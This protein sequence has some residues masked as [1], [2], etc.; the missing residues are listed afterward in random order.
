MSKT[1]SC[2]PMSLYAFSY[3]PQGVD[4]QPRIGLI[5][6]RD[7]WRQ[8]GHMQDL[9]AFFLTARKALVHIPPGKRLIDPQVLHLLE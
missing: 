6:N 3:G 8:H 9:D 4:I 5:Q 2:G 7:L 1:P